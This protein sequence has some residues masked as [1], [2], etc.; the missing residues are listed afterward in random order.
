MRNHRRWRLIARI[1]LK[2]FR[3]LIQH[4]GNPKLLAAWKHTY[5]WTNHCLFCAEAKRL[6]HMPLIDH[7]VCGLCPLNGRSADGFGCIGERRK[8][9]TANMTY[10]QLVRALHDEEPAS[11]VRRAAVRRFKFLLNR[12]QKRGIL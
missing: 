12:L 4:P 3:T 5:G 10:N 6:A 2:R 8:G 7:K 11:A 9:D 1:M